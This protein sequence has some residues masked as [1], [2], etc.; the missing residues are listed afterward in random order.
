MVRGRSRWRPGG[1]LAVETKRAV[2]HSSQSLLVIPSAL[3][4]QLA[5]SISL[6]GSHCTSESPSIEP[7]RR[8]VVS[9]ASIWLES[10]DVWADDAPEIKV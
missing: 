2:S 10:E 1:Y 8:V 7:T 5:S 6:A 9:S 3:L 4:F